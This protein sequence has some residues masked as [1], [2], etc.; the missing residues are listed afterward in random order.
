MCDSRNLYTT[1]CAGMKVTTSRAPSSLAPM[2]IATSGNTATNT[3]TSR[4]RSSPPCRTTTPSAR[5]TKST[6][7]HSAA[8]ETTSPRSSRRRST[9]PSRTITPL[10]RSLVPHCR[11]RGVR[12]LR[13]LHESHPRPQGHPWSIRSNISIHLYCFYASKC[14]FLLQT[15]QKRR[16]LGCVIL[17]SGFLWP[18]IR[19]HA[20]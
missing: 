9:P 3:P 15:C 17:R 16:M 7:S 10:G 5:T 8:G 6:G 13:S 11:L 2:P 12:L 14:K 18:R 1:L 4:P 19:V 20:T